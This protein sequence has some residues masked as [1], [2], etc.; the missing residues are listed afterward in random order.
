MKGNEPDHLDEEV[1]IRAL[2]ESSDLPPG[3]RE[4]LARCPECQGEKNRLEQD[5]EKLGRM[6]RDLSP[7]PGRE[8]LL[9]EPME[10][11]QRSWGWRFAAGAAVSICLVVLVVS[12]SL[13]LGRSPE[14]VLISLT[15]EMWED[16]GLLQEVRGLQRNPLPMS[17]RNI[18]VESISG[19]DEG[20]FDFVVPLTDNETLSR[21]KRGEWIC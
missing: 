19:L 13:R 1:L 21:G 16:E 9:P 2:V 11:G 12:G 4:H 17:L 8:I 5:L 7:S 6:A 10:A 14:S 18:A 3:A 15:E 20:F